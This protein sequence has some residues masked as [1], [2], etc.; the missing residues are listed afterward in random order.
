MSRARRRI[1]GLLLFGSLVVG[2]CSSESSYAGIVIEPM[3][4]VSGT[5]LPDGTAAGT[6]VAFAA[7]P[8]GVR[9][10]YFGYTACPDVCPTTL[11]DIR[12]ALEKLSTADRARVSLVMVTIDPARDRPEVLAR[13]V[14]SFV[15][16]AHAAHTDDQAALRAIAERFGADYGVETAADGTVEVVH[17]AFVYLVDAEGHIRVT[18]PFGTKPPDMRHDLEKLLGETAR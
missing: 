6:T 14:T 18:W 10:V 1:V 11:A 17:T 2:A 13:Y 3:R 5:G 4:D 9:L 12:T 15:P 8:G 16:G 7:D